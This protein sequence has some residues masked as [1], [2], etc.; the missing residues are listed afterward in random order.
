M[1]IKIFHH[2]FL[3]FRQ[4]RFFWANILAI[5][6]VVVVGLMFGVLKGLDI[7]TPPR[8]G[9]DSARCEGHGSGGSR[10]NVPEPRFVRMFGFQMSKIKS[11]CILEYNPAAGQ[12][13]KEGRTIYLTINTIEVPLHIVP[14][15]RTTVP[16]R[17]AEARILASGFKLAEIQYIGREK[18]W[19]YGVKYP[20]PSVSIGEKCPPVQELTLMVEMEA[21][22]GRLPGRFCGGTVETGCPKTPRQMSPGSDKHLTPIVNCK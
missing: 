14:M 15:W 19:V 16:L 7:Y 5:L 9:C 21:P 8:R 12:K 18:D 13:V 1:T 10:E 11:G 20:G 6:S 3:K 17:Q 2:L 22:E 4:N